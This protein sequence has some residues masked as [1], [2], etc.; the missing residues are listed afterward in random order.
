MAAN[1]LIAS[2]ASISAAL[3]AWLFF[4]QLQEKMGYYRDIVTEMTT[5]KFSELFMFVDIS[6]YFYYYIAAVFCL[7]ILVILLSGKISLGLL[8]FFAIL[9]SPYL[10][11]KRLIQKRLKQFE[12]QLPDALMMIAGSIKS[13]SSL[14]IALDS[15]IQESSPPLSQEFSIFVRERK[16]GMD[17]DT[18][19]AN[20]EQRLPLEDL[21]LAL[22]AVRISSEVGGNLGE[23][24][25]SL[26]ETLRKKLVME[27]KVESLTSQ[28]KLQGLVMSF[29]PMFL[30]L[31]LLK[32]EPEAMGKMFTTKIGWIVVST[33]ICMQLLGFLAIR[34]ITTIDV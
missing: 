27:G 26:A 19:F 3:F 2:L 13:G 24:L 8:T 23:T 34:K 28:G 9:L 1:I 11:L 14:P 31:A 29:L 25:E 7:P 32:L 18:A 15:L 21:S 10:I 20:M 17:R 4:L 33:I 16:L 12:R 6:R 22:S 30:M 5:N